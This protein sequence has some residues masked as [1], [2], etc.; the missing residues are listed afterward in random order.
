[1]PLVVHRSQ[2]VEDLVDT[3]ARVL[4]ASW[5]DDPFE[6]VPILIGS[7]GMERW[8][9]HELAT[10]LGGVARLAFVFPRTAF[11]GAA[12]W[13]LDRPSPGDRSPFWEAA[14]GTQDPWSGPRLL[15]RVLRSMRALLQRQLG[16]PHLE[17]VR[18]YLGPVGGDVRA[19]ELTFAQEVSRA[20]ERLLHER[21]DDVLPWTKDPMAAPSEHRWLASLLRELHAD[22]DRPCPAQRLEQLRTLT[23]SPT[24][25]RL[26]VFGLS[27]MQSGDKQWLHVLQRH[28][29]VQMFALAASR[30]WLQDIRR[31]G[32]AAESKNVMLAASGRPS[33]D[34]QEWLEAVGYREPRE[35]PSP[36]R[37]TSLLGRVQDWIDR[38]DPLPGDA[39]WREHASCPSIE[40]HACHG[41]LRQCEDLRDELL[42]RFAG[43]PTLEPRHVL[44]MTPDVATY[45]PLLAAVFA[46]CCCRDDGAPAI[47]LHIS[48]LGIRSTNP[49][50]D[51]LLRALALA[52]ERVTASRLVEFVAIGPVRARFGL[53]EQDLADIRAMIVK[54]GIRWAWDAGDRA[55][56]GQPPIDQNTLRFGL[57]RLALGVLMHDAG[58]LAVVPARADGLQAAVPLEIGPR[59][60]VERFGRLVEVCERLRSTCEE[61]SKPASS[62]GWRER[63]RAM[64]DDLT[65]VGDGA[66][67][68]RMQVEQ[69]LD[70]LLPDADG[71]LF[72][73]C[74]I[75]A[76]LRDAFDLPEHGDRP[77]TGAVTVC[78]VEPMRSVPFRVIALLGLDDGAFPRAATPAAWDPFA[79]PGAG[80]Y[81]RRTVDRHLFLEAILCARDAL[82]VFG[83][84]FEPQRGAPMALSVVV[85]EL[86]EIVAAGVGGKPEERR[87]AHPLQPWSVRAF[88]ADARSRPFDP[89]WAE[90]AR[91]RDARRLA[92][93]AATKADATWPEEDHRPQQIDA[94]DLAGAL[95][96]PQKELLGKRL[97]LVFE[98]YDDGDVRD[99]EPL[100]QDSLE[101][102]K[103][104]DLAL[105]ELSGGAE[106]AVEAIEARLRGEGVLPVSAA[107]RVALQQ[108]I[109][110][111]RAAHRSAGEIPGTRAEPLQFSCRAE[112]VVVAATARDVR[113]DGAKQRLVWLTASKSPNARQQLVAWITLVA[114]AASGIPVH[115]AHIAACGGAIE[116][117]A[118]SDVAAARAHLSALVRSWRDVR[119]SPV[120]L[121]PSLSREIVAARIRKPAGTPADWVRAAASA[122]W[123]GARAAGPADRHDAWVQPLF[124]HLGIEDL[125][126]RAEALVHNANLVWGPLL[127][128]RAS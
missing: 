6:A 8:L 64:L 68:L 45:A 56:H 46:R 29:D 125:V 114:A 57:E 100:E 89:V 52:E 16:E 42:R 73:R 122:Q 99:R 88:D 82:L 121:F 110:Q 102:W 18:G 95:A 36:E 66:A 59:E 87:I 49:V 33:R 106:P 101:G 19:R 98:T 14:P 69:K 25:R 35:Y 126:E 97:G 81:D 91:A 58:G 70:E 38:A 34:L 23:P 94:E 128:A 75:A 63:L 123:D 50:A 4:D 54:A 77:V 47:P 62:R 22:A 78:G 86:T 103:V 92:G 79:T 72:D 67:W 11:D 120:L 44:V 40:V 71:L 80:Q 117:R 43:D 55:N 27:T 28:L 115:G 109:E 96:R 24:Q 112:D 108:C 51:A 118:P 2:R 65:R 61:A 124:G 60:R 83:T 32:A 17:R 12:R 53:D 10:R 13:L 90:A 119:R 111:A 93:L 30:V 15:M 84:G 26:L 41:P 39:P 37:A 113:S 48:D 116:L 3:L 20:I 21:P 127:E 1:M 9:R 105:R 7:R 74:A 5:P 107:G 76:L 104:R 85:S 31:G